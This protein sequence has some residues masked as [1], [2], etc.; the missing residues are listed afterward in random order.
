MKYKFLKYL[1]LIFF[2]LTIFFLI[3]Y[4]K[5]L[6]AVI[7]LYILLAFSLLF[8]RFTLWGVSDLLPK[9]FYIQDYAFSVIVPAKDEPKERLVKCLES[10]I[11]SDGKKEIFLGDDGSKVSVKE[12][13][14]DYPEIIKKIK[15]I[16]NKKNIGKVETQVKLINLC[17]YDIIVNVDSDVVVKKDALIKLVSAF[18]DKHVGIANGLIKIISSGSILDRLQEHQYMCAYEIA[19]VSMG[20]FGISHC[21]SGEMLAFRK[22]AFMP[23]LD[24]YQ[25]KKFLGKKL[26]HGQDRFMTNIFLREGYKSINVPS[27]IGYTYPR[28][29]YTSLLKQYWRWRKSSIR[30]SLRCSKYCALKNPYLSL[31]SI[32]HITLPFIFM[33]LI[34]ALGIYD[35]YYFKFSHFLIILSSIITITFI[36]ELPLI[37]KYPRLILILPISVIFNLF[38][39]LP[40]WFVA[41]FNLDDN[42]WGT[43]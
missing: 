25:N 37:I 6:F 32:L 31:W 10:I 34:I 2:I 40:L 29:T 30:E 3:I 26:T 1:A 13:L 38:F 35:I 27:S 15:I 24:E 23:F 33:M 18:K 19:R 28:E 43:R 9:K 16:T 39:V 22:K 17:K 21:C 41:L 8:I 4:P 7:R 12:L 42:S 20:R 14:K 36:S 5:F 11:K